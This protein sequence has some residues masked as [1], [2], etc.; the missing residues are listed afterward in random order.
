MKVTL[1]SASAAALLALGT[2]SVSAGAAPIGTGLDGLRS[3]NSLAQQADYDGGDWRRDR[4]T[5]W[6]RHS[7]DN[8]D[9]RWSSRN[10]SDRDDGGRPAWR[11][12][13]DRHDRDD[14]RWR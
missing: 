14:R 6:Q 11:D 2:W 9:R 7:R 8:D 3:T 5:E 12:R 4:G 1:P 10:R 13:D